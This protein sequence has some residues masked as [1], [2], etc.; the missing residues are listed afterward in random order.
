MAKIYAPNKQ[1]TGISA[2]VPFAGGTAEC[3]DPARLNW[4]REHGYQVEGPT[5]GAKKPKEKAEDK[6]PEAG[7]DNGSNG[8]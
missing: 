2:G 3:E 8:Q 7:G 5:K 4:F 1:Y 6:K